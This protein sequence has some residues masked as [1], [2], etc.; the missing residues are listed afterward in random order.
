MLIKSPRARYILLARSLFN[1]VNGV[2]FGELVR[3]QNIIPFIISNFRIQTNKENLADTVVK[4]Y[5][6]FNAHS[7]DALLVPK[8]FYSVESIFD[9]QHQMN[10]DIISYFYGVTSCCPVLRT[11]QVLICVNPRYNLSPFMSVQQLRR[12]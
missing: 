1:F 5:T 6:K 4:Y 11:P 3:N 8:T 7:D 10:T 2:N 9:R 12:E